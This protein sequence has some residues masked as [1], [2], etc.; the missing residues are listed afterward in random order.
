VYFGPD[1]VWSNYSKVAESFEATTWFYRS[2]QKCDNYAFNSVVAIK[3]S[4]FN[5]QIHFTFGKYM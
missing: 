1:P 4:S 5:K 2:P 3:A